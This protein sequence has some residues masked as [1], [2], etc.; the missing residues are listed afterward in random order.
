LPAFLGLDLGASGL[1]AVIIGATG[2]LLGAANI[3]LS[4]QL[5]QPGWSEQNPAD[6]LA[7]LRLAVPEAL[8]AAG[9]APTSLT[10]IGVT[11]GAHTPVLTGDDGAPL[12]PAIMWSDQRASAEAALL[13]EKADALI[14]ETGLNRVNA[15]WTLAMLAWVRAHEPH[16]AAATRRVY[17]A[18]D[19]LRAALTGTWETDYSDAIGTLLADHRTQGWSPALCGLIGW[20]IATLPPIRRATDIVGHVTDQKFGLAPGTKVIC[21]AMDTT[22][23]LFGAGALTPGM[24]S[25]KLATAGVISEVTAGPV[26][27]PPVSCYPHIATGLFYTAAGTNSC[28][29]ALRWLRDT[30]NLAGGFAGIDAAAATVP[31]GAGG[32]IFHPYLQG[33]RAP[34]WDARLRGDFIGL[35]M[36]HTPAHLC[37]AVLEGVAFSL[38]DVIAASPR[39][40]AGPARLLGG[41]AASP[42]WRQIIADVTG[43]TLE[44]PAGADAAFGAAL[45]AALGA[46]AFASPAQAVDSCVHITASTP[47]NA[48]NAA[49]YRKL[50]DIYQRSQALMAPLAHE[51]SALF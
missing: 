45:L 40:L 47:P 21:G 13:R 22:T 17:L 44:Q 39:P 25:I 9:L 14:I 43:L 42:L 16:I 38:R 48:G 34:Y 46:G 8:R 1:K 28:A 41:G 27:N 20:D 30:L 49:I 11:A 2:Q 35:T 6:W 24:A 3:G 18:K 10:A 32:L 7:A 15:T 36:A 26:V 37:R 50:F 31:P 51:L 33:E 4:T 12:R 23:E 5:P 19:W 29:S